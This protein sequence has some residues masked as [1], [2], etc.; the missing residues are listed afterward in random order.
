[1]RTDADLWWKG[2]SHPSGVSLPRNVIERGRF[3]HEEMRMAR[4]RSNV[5]DL[6]V[7]V[8]TSSVPFVV[9]VQAPAWI[10]ALA[11]SLAAIATGTRQVFGWQATWASFAQASGQ[12]EREVVR[13]SVGA[14]DYSEGT[15]ATELLACRVEDITAAETDSWARRLR[16]GHRAAGVNTNSSAP[17]GD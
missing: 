4:L 12:I 7:L 11:G 5:A 13:F 6:S 17:S 14:D 10:A 15:A 9:A 3:Y 8:L 16:E 1:M 2:L